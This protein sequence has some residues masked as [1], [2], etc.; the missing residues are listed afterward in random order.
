MFVVYYI[1]VQV[2]W[3]ITFAPRAGD[4]LLKKATPARIPQGYK[5]KTN[6]NLRTELWHVVTH[7][8]ILG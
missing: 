4:D 3:I 6:Q 1:H 8:M 2:Y 5:Q 7:Y